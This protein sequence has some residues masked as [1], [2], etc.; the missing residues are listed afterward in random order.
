MRAIE[1]MSPTG[2]SPFQVLPGGRRVSDTLGNVRIV[3]AREEDPPFFIDGEVFEEDTWLALSTQTDVIRSPD[4][5]V[6]VMTRVWE[7]KPENPGSVTVKLGPPARLLAVVHDL[8]AEPSCTEEWVES[9]LYEVFVSCTKHRL[10]ALKLPLLGS[11]HGNLPAIRFMV[12]LRRSL[13]RAV[14]E[15]A[16][17]P[18]RRLW[19]VRGSEPGDELLHALAG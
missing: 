8:D 13:Q 1:K 5:P 19:L 9:A 12:L 15:D 17:L 10:H 2:D 18:L 4:H 16:G 6:R 14:D 3:V 11:K 7:A